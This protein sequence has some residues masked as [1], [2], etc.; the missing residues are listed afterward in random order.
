MIKEKIGPSK[1]SDLGLSGPRS[2]HWQGREDNLSQSVVMGHRGARTR[3]WGSGAW[4]RAGLG[5]CQP[6]SLMPWPT[7]R[8]QPTGWIRGLHMWHQKSSSLSPSSYRSRRRPPITVSTTAMRVR[9]TWDLSTTSSRMP[10]RKGYFMLSTICNI[11]TQACC[12]HAGPPSAFLLC[13]L[14]TSGEQGKWGAATPSTK[15]GS[16]LSRLAGPTLAS[17]SLRG[18]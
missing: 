13:L 2:C 5:L 6:D 9:D 3:P 10:C 11:R 17:K 7:R 1:L 18:Q 14:Q 12:G 4:G 8:D 16:E 15:S